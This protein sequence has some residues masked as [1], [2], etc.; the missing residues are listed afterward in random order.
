MPSCLAALFIV[1]PFGT[2]TS[3][4]S[5]VSFTVSIFSDLFYRIMIASNLHFSM[6]AP[7]LMQIDGF[8]RCGSLRS[9][10]IA[11]T[12]QILAQAVQ[13]TQFSDMIKYSMRSRHL[14]AG[15]FFTV[16][17]ASYSSLKL[18][19]VE[20]TGFGEL[21]PRPQSEVSLMT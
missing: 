18:S 2:S 14:P 6:H 15:H 11:F 7:H 1:V 5:I 3:L 4:L 17:C 16:T 9:P 20:S 19:R 13:P 21:W 10:V 8:I 12:G